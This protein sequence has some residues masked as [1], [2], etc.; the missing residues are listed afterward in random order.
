MATLE[1]AQELQSYMVDLRNY[2]HAHPELGLQEFNTC[3]KIEEELSTIGIK[4]FF[5]HLVAGNNRVPYPARGIIA[6]FTF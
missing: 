5:M 3:A 6:F 4:H 2:L 1:E